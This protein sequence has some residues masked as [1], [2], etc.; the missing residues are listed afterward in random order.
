MVAGIVLF[1][2]GLETALHHL[3]DHLDLL[4]AAALCAGVALY[5]GGQVGF[6]VLAIRRVFRRRT[7]AAV[8]LLAL[9][10]L[11]HAIPALAALATVAAISAG[12]VAYE[13]LARRDARLRLRHPD[14]LP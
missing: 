6:M 9:I 7:L 2:F 14:Q 12:V 11:A 4:P 8:V 10:P 13:A 1:A 3:D 5:L